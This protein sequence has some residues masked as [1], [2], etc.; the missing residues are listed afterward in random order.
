MLCMSV[1][2]Q[3]IESNKVNK[4]GVILH[5]R[6]SLSP[7]RISNQL[8]KIDI[9]SYHHIYLYFCQNAWIKERV[10]RGEKIW[11]LKYI[12]NADYPK[13]KMIKNQK[14]Q[15]ETLTFHLSA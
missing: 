12:W 9:M 10:W 15:E 3:I 2:N 5:L 8:P 11:Y 1:Q 6:V 14:P 7:K 4:D 13:M